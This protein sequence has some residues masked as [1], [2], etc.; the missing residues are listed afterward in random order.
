MEAKKQLEEWKTKVEKADDVKARLVLE[1]LEEDENK[2]KAQ[3]EMM[4]GVKKQEDFQKQCAQDVSR[5]QDEFAKLAKRKRDLLEKLRRIQAELEARRAQS[6]RLKQKFK[7]CAPVSDT[8]LTFTKKTEKREESDSDSDA[9]AD[10]DGD[11]DPVRG[12]FTISQRT[13]LLLEGGQALI[14]FEEEKVASQIVKVGKCTVSCDSTALDVK[15]KRINL[16]PVVKF[17]V[18]LNV[19][20]K[21]VEIQNVPPSMAEERM[22][23]RLQISFSRPSRGGGEVRRVD[24]DSDTGTG[25]VTFVHPGAAERLALRGKFPVDLDSEVNVKVE[26]SYHYQLRK[27]QTFCG[28]LKRTILLVDINDLGD[29]EELQDYLEIHFQK[30]SNHGGEIESIKYI[31]KGKALQAALSEDNQ[32]E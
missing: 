7:I 10:S 23:D 14:T 6:A 17:E 29:E 1:K 2:S 15:P 11:S 18:H 28:S 26:P 27:F 13:A 12:V 16:D 25:R 8:Q 9:D 32:Q 20:R 30:P 31:S 22:K 19:S 5:V 24:Y 3:Q 4:A 21:N